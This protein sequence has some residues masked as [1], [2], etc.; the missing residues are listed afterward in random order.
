MSPNPLRLVFLKTK[1]KKTG[2]WPHTQVGGDVKSYRE[3]ARGRQETDL[4]WLS[5]REAKDCWPLPTAQKRKGKILPSLGGTAPV[6]TL[7]SDL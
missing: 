7:I 4:M 1:K 5:A 2:N 3:K 6:N